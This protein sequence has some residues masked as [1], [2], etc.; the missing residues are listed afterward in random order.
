MSFSLPTPTLQHTIFDNQVRIIS[1]AD[2]SYP[3]KKIAI[4]VDGYEYHSDKERWQRDMEQMN[5]LISVGW[6]ICDS[7]QRRS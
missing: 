3:E 2:F 6:N 7:R 5:I 4:F 1:R